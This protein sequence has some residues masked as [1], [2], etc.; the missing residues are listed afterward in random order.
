MIYDVEGSTQLK[1]AET[2]MLRADGIDGMIMNVEDSRFSRVV[3]TVNRLVGIK[4]IIR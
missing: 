2:Y 1:K 3:F 4:K